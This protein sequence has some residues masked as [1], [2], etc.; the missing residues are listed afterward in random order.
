MLT[1]ILS[2]N[3]ITDVTVVR[4][5]VPCCSGLMKAVENAIKN[6]GKNIPLKKVTISSRGGVL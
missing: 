3:D 1:A 4:M 2:N 5:E 6:S